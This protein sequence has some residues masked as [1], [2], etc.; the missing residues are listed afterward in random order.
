M[1]IIQAK[2]VHCVRS[3]K[4]WT[5]YVTAS[6]DAFQRV[7]VSRTAVEIASSIKLPRNDVIDLLT[8]VTQY[9]TI[10]YSAPTPASPKF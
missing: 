6:T 3:V 5:I 2:Q 10:G 7:A 9:C 8:D 4:H 1:R